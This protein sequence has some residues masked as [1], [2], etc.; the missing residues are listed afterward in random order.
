[1]SA[2]S[3]ALLSL[4]LFAALLVLL[5]A[6]A[7]AQAERRREAA[8]L[9]ALGIGRNELAWS[10]ALEWLTLGLIAA[11]VASILAG[12][13]GWLLAR[14]VFRFDYQPGMDLPMVAL[15]VALAIC[16]AAAGVAARTATRAPPADSLR[17]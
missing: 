10:M 17:A 14:D 15:A 16:A 9:R 2:A 12:L 8:L 3:Q 1:M 11:I 7:Y 13:A 6:L 4:A 5:G